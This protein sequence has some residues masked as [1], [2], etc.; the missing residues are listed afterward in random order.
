[1]GSIR[2]WPARPQRPEEGRLMR[3]VL[4]S[5]AVLAGIG[6]ASPA[7][8]DPCT[9]PL[10]STAGQSFSG[11]VRY[12]SDGDSL[13]IGASSDPQ[14]WIE[15]R[16]ADF[17]APEL[18]SPS[19][20]TGQRRVRIGRAWPL[21]GLHVRARPQRAGSGVRQGDSALHD[22]RAIGRNLAP[23]GRGASGR[24]LGPGHWSL[25]LLTL[26]GAA[27]GPHRTHCRT[28]TATPLY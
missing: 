4:I 19:R 8:A 20:C 5:C 22:R 21:G 10:P 16:L 15:V 14:S 27:N 3:R 9:G 26:L 2:A 7:A 17:D 1:M 23:A 28:A 12:V 25:P 18:H 11:P 6:M 24:S 13:C